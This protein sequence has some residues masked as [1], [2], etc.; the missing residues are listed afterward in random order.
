VACLIGRLGAALRHG[1]ELGQT[2]GRQ[3]RD[4]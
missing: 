2:M 4:F 3:G 1:D